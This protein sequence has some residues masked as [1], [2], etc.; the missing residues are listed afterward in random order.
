MDYPSEYSNYYGYKA[1]YGD[2]SYGDY[3]FRLDQDLTTDIDAVSV[4]ID[5]I[6]TGSGGDVPQDYARVVY[7][8]RSFT[9]RT[10]A[11]KIYVIFGDAPPHAAPNGS[12]TLFNPWATGSLLF[13]GKG[14]PYGGDPGRDEVANTGDDLDYAQAVADAASRQIAIVGVYCFN[15]GMYYVNPEDSENNF[16]Y[17][18]YVTGGLYAKTDSALNPSDIAA[19]IVSMIREMATKN[20]GELGLQVEESRYAG[21]VTTPEAYSDVPWGSSKVFNPVITAPAGTADGDYTF[22]IDLVGDGVV[23]GTIAVTEQVKSDQ[24]VT[25]IAVSLDI[26]PGSCPNSFNIKEKGVL[27]VAILGD[28]NLKASSIDPKSITLSRYEG[29]YGVNPIRSS[30]EDVASAST[31]T[32]S[33]GFKSGRPD[34]KQDLN[35]K[36]DSQEVVKQLGIKKNEGCIRVKVTGTIRSKDPALNGKQI[37]GSDYLRVL[38]T[39][40]GSCGGGDSKDD[41]GSCD[42]KGSC[43]GNGSGKDKGSSDD[44]NPWDDEGSH[45]NHGH[46]NDRDS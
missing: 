5:G 46:G 12:T 40:S 32:C 25:P 6:N 31:K 44:G 37:Q 23:L 26:K 14:A 35:L 17:M 3:A 39:G 24:L 45:D 8:A 29:T 19:Q 18:A 11:K 13:T 4:K 9:W 33:C 7:E 42:N 30:L 16:R 38:D 1:K 2:P 36:F 10:D 28:K 41:K 15:S 43:G 34:R 22:H 20:I 27:P 21:W